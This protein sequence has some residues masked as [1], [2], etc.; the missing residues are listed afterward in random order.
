MGLKQMI[1]KQF[2]KPT[3]NFGRFVGWLM[4]VKNNERVNWTFEKLNLRPSDILLEIGYGPGMTV[5]KVANN[6]TS[7]FIAGI[8]HSQIMLQQASRRNKKH[9]KNAKVKLEYGTVWDL[10]YPKHH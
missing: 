10:N 4:S 1:I 3:G 2:A 7:G 5:E 6:L 9:I 8:D